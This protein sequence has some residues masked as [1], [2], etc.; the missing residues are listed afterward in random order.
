[1]KKLKKII[2]LTLSILM[3][4]S[5]LA[6]APITSNAAQTDVQA[7]GTTYS[8]TTGDCSWSLD[9]ST[10]ELTISGNGAMGSY[11]SSSTAPW[12]SYRSYIKTATISYGVTTV[13]QWSFYNCTSLTS[14]TIPSSVLSIG[15]Y[16]FYYCTS[17]TSITIPSSITS[18]GSDVFNYCTSL[19]SVTI[20]SSVTSIGGYA[21]NYCTS[22]TSITIPS[23][24]VSIGSDAFRCCTSLTSITIPSSITSIGYEAFYKCKSLED[25]YYAGTESEWDNI[26]I[27]SYNDP[28]TNA[29]IHYSVSTNG[30]ATTNIILGETTTSL[31]IGDEITYVC[32]LKSD[33]TIGCGQF[34]LNYPENL[35]EIKSVAFPLTS[36]A[37][38]NYTENLTDELKF[39]FSNVITGYDF[40][41]SA[42]LIEVV[43]NVKAAGEG[44]ISL[45]KEVL[46]NMNDANVLNEAV[47]TETI[48]A[49]ERDNNTT[50]A[51][52]TTIAPTTEVIT[53]PIESTQET[54]VTEP[55]EVTQETFIIEST[56]STTV[57]YITEAI[58]DATEEATAT[59]TTEPATDGTVAPTL[60]ADGTF[61][62][63]VMV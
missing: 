41:V 2:S 16:S 58:T 45:D 6:V 15:N 31:I 5:V 39:N 59:E 18:I 49:S 30:E 40:S 60:P 10:G 44:K 32:K 20:P 63:V 37:K 61:H 14:V 48:T 54:V 38:Y 24:V 29:T 55:A 21:F 62:V 33:S 19:T 34:T 8:G 13:G 42:V 26:Y 51:P 9:T 27:N 46:S 28:L 25:V 1:M 43:F 7:V 22:L 17:L 57:T 47:F 50:I 12:Y 36:D 52:A 53:D 3:L 4:I 23:S 56:E 11:L 35:L